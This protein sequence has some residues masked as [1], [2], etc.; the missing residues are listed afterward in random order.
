MKKPL[1]S[2]KT[3]ALDAD[4]VRTGETT[5]EFLQRQCEPRFVEY[6]KLI[7]SLFQDLPIKHCETFRGRLRSKDSAEFQ[8]ATFEMQL[9]R[10]LI[11][12]GLEIEI[13][14]KL[15]ID[16]FVRIEHQSCFIEATV[17]GFGEGA[18]SSTENEYDAIVKLRQGLPNPHLN[19]RL[20]AEGRLKKTLAKNKIIRPFK[21][22]LDRFTREEFEE[23]LR[24][25]AWYDPRYTLFEEKCETKIKVGDWTLKG[26]IELPFP[27]Y[28]G[29]IYGPWRSG[30]MD[31]S[32]PLL[33][34][35]QAKAKRWSG[36]DLGHPFIVA[37]N[38]CHSE[39]TWE[40]DYSDIKR[41]LTGDPNAADRASF[42]LDLHR[43]S[44]VIVVGN[45]CMGAERMAPVKLFRNGDKEIPD[46]LHFLEEKQTFGDLLG[47]S[48]PLGRT[49]AL[50]RS[51][52][53][54][55]RHFAQPMV[56][57]AKRLRR[58]ENAD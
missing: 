19:I 41:A 54:T 21:E 44:G 35:V 24:N 45:A 38:N 29:Q 28:E 12:L 2:V 52:P 15:P 13:E 56:R 23:M 26:T 5:F 34:S 55:A 47:L 8:A 22:L 40:D 57:R 39:F 33:R 3:D 10:M 49:I 36:I 17:C 18:F 6:R 25:Y 14:G 32:G 31:T 58:Q 48:W 30:A 43:I 7:E 4:P 53:R 11:R 50:S 51:G 37:V 1:F 9:Y 42:R 16:F 20:E 46:F 27:Q